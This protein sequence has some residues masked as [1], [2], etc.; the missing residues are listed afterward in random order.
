MNE[1]SVGV[2]RLVRL[3]Y[4]VVILFVCREVYDVLRNLRVL[5]IRLVHHTVRS[6]DEAVLVDTC[7][8]CQRVDQTDVRSLRCLDRAHT[9]IVCI[10]NI[11]NLESGTVSGKTTWSEGGKSTLVCELRQR[12][13]L[14]HE[15]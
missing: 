13:V 1:M 2:E 6:L 3:C 14:I 9:T 5:R 10:V 15:L 8:G 12:V 11:S 4:D 7:V